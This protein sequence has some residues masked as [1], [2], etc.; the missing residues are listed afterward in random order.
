M[1]IIAKLIRNILSALNSEESPNQVAVGFA[2]GA[3]IGLLPL[4]GLLP[5]VL[6]FLSFLININ[7]GMVALGTL[8]FKVIAFAVD[9]VANHLGYTLLTQIA[10]LRPFWTR[11]YNMPIVPYTRFNNTIVLGSFV[12]GVIG[13][14]PLFFFAKWAVLQYRAKVRDK[15]LKLKIMKLFQASKIYQYYQ[16][17]RGF[18]A[19]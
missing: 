15:I 5:P 11:L 1:L 9:P 12:I 6:V 7:L 19:Q 8:L 10:A 17:Y 13:M 4:K 14:I 2:Y 3:L 18:R 16:T